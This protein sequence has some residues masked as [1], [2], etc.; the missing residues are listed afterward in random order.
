MRSALAILT[1]EMAFRQVAGGVPEDGL[2]QT[3]PEPAEQVLS[4]FVD[5]QVGT[6]NKK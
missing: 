2:Q 4:A 5:D 6:M 3:G 1:K